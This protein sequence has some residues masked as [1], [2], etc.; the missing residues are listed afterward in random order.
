[1][2]IPWCGCY[3]KC[4]STTYDIPIPGLF[5]WFVIPPIVYLWIAR[6][7]H[8]RRNWKGRSFASIVNH[9][10]QLLTTSSYGQ[11]SMV[12]CIVTITNCCCSPRS[13][14]SMNLIHPEHYPPCLSNHQMFAS[15]LPALSHR[16]QPPS[17]IIDHHQPL[18]MLV[19]HQPPSTQPPWASDY[20]PLSINHCHPRIN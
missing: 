15:P 1:M 13:P 17:T 20:Q 9:H 4:L 3:F 14:W 8:P 2:V 6:T 12:R 16:H 19:N 10:Q 7:L 18:L 5:Q 11:L